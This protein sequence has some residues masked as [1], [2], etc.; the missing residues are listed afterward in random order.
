MMIFADS[1]SHYDQAQM[2][3]MWDIVST[4][5]GVGPTPSSI[6]VTLVQSRTSG[7]FGAGG[8][9]FGAPNLSSIS[10]VAEAPDPQYIQKNYDGISVVY[11]SLAVQQTGEQISGTNAG[12]PTSVQIPLKGG[13]LITFLDGS[14]TQVGIYIMQSGQLRAVRSTAADT[15]I[16]LVEI[17]TNP[18]SGLPTLTELGI[19]DAAISSNAFDFLQFKITH[20]TSGSIEVRRGDGSL[21]WLLDN[22]NTAISGNNRSASM[23]VGGYGAPYTSNKGTL[24]PHYLRAIVSDVNILNETVNGDDALD[25]VTFIGDR[26]W[27]VRTPTTDGFYTQWTCSTG[28]NHAALVD[29]IPP[30]TTDY[31][32]TSAVGNIDS[33]NTDAPSGPATASCIVAYTMY[34]QKTTGGTTG[35]RGLMRESS[36]DRTGTEFQVPSPWAYK[37][38]F[39]CSK[40]GGGAI[41]VADFD[42]AEH[43]YKLSS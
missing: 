26:H 34:L 42:A 8:V 17:G 33:F 7:R 29:E 16:Y 32:S 28:S 43:G 41:T 24:Q 13:R 23:L 20:G 21:F 22:V 19:S 10:A 18:N 9:T 4:P 40:P 1:F 15:G 12:V 39:L 36:T 30:N 3:D 27:E 2:P 38:S 5:Y 25:P 35:V 11:G 6:P 14:T 31:N 37:Q